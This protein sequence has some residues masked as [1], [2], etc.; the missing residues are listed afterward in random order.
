M[1]LYITKFK[2]LLVTRPNANWGTG[3]N[4]LGA[5][6]M[7]SNKHVIKEDKY[8]YLCIDDCL[9]TLEKSWRVFQSV[10]GRWWGNTKNRYAC[11]VFTFALSPNQ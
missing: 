8:M 4:K 9:S 3:E 6:A 5:F 7:K 11:A 10:V 1:Y 2:T